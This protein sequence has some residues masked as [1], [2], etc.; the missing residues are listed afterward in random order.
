MQ[1]FQQSSRTLVQ[2]IERF[3]SSLVANISKTITLVLFVLVPFDAWKA[4]DSV[5]RGQVQ[6]MERT[7]GVWVGLDT[8]KRTLSHYQHA[9]F[10]DAFIEQERNEVEDWVF[11][12]DGGFELRSDLKGNANLILISKDRVPV[13]ISI[14]PDANIQPLQ[15][16]LSRGMEL[17]GVVHDSSG[18]PISG[19]TVSIRPSGEDYEIPSFAIPQWLTEA[20]G[21]FQVSG[22][23]PREYLLI[24]SANAYAPIIVP[25]F[26]IPSTEVHRLEVELVKGHYVSGKVTDVNGLPVTNV[27]VRS[28]WTRSHAEVRVSDGVMKVG[29]KNRF[30][31]Y[32][33]QTQTSADGTFRLGPVEIATDGSIW[34][35]SPEFGSV[36]VRNLYAP[37]DELLLRLSKEK[38]QGRVLDVTTSEPI[39]EISVTVFPPWGSGDHV[40]QND[41]HFELPI[42]PI[43]AAGAVILIDSHGYFP[44]I[45]RL[46]QGSTGIYDLGHVMLEQERI[47]KGIVRNGETGTPMDGV[48]I[49]LNAD[50]YFDRSISTLLGNWFR[51]YRTKSNEE[52]EYLLKK[53]PRDAD[54]L[55][56]YVVGH[57]ERDTDIPTDIEEFDIDLYFNGVLEGSLVLP[58]GRPVDGTVT[59]FGPMV[60]ESILSDNGVF[61]WEG[62]N[63]GTYR[64]TG[65]S[66]AGLVGSETVTMEPGDR[67]TDVE[68][69][70][71][72]GWSAKG[73]ITGLRGNESVEISVKDSDRRVLIN[74]WFGNGAYAIHGVPNEALITARTSTG[75]LSIRRFDNGNEE[76]E[77]IDF[78]FD[79]E[80]QLRGFVLSGG[81]PIQGMS[82]S[83]VPKNL[84]HVAGFTKTDAS[85]SYVVKGLSDGLHDVRTPTGYSLEIV[86][87]GE[88]TSDIELPQNSI[89]GIVRS[90]QTRM[91]IGGG[92]VV[93]NGLDIPA[94]QGPSV[95]IKTIGSDGTFSFVGLIEGDYE[96]E[97][98]H[99]HAEKVFR[100]I[101][102][103]GSETIE[104]I[105]QCANTQECIYGGYGPRRTV[106][107]R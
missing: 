85:G 90:E 7:E 44:W 78:R 8:G 63:P 93:V 100:R 12:P 14:T 68:L 46:Y 53:L 69:Q 43:D 91:P 54:S 35:D 15:I 37:R 95:G 40:R 94:S 71:K 64:V 50:R 28:S 9:P 20:D 92:V 105:V 34:A 80:S 104:L 55:E 66:E 99:P 73:S 86:I 47:L 65:E 59:L 29:R 51:E 82:L 96:V 61:R 4:D 58:D 102:V 62:L 88:T 26:V 1:G 103:E 49:G 79:G 17:E 67:L 19:A 38:V 6:G 39:E 75:L 30:G 27:L 24:V 89:S 10:D 84:E 5:I 32:F 36:R 70:V 101:R 52:G 56:L 25:N 23:E 41:G 83:I 60:P 81:E 42:D 77:P 33:P 76:G 72:P 98:V 106:K 22:L 18:I 45:G 16:N 107:T 11:A 3:K 21:S 97:I 2:A 74:K 57:G 13:Q 87:D 31:W 48:S